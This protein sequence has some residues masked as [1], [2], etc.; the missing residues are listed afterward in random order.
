MCEMIPIGLAMLFIGYMHFIV[1]N[2]HFELV[3]IILLHVS[4]PF[5]YTDTSI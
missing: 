1:V 3:L 2:E 4:K 5:M